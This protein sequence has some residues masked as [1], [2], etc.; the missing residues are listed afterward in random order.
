MSHRFFLL[1]AI[2]VLLFA[3][4]GLAEEHATAPAHES[5]SSAGAHATEHPAIDQRLVPIP[6]SRDTIVTAVWVIV[7]FVALLAILYPTAWKNVLAGLKKREERIRGDI[8]EAEAA[9]AKAEE[10]LRQYNAQLATAEGR[11]R[12]LLAKATADG[13]KLA[14]DI[15]MRAQAE[16]EDAKNRAQRD[17]EAAR[18]QALT[19]IYNHTASLATRIAEKIIG[20]NLNESDQED[21]VR[22]SLDELETIGRN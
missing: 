15:R 1:M 8:A 18:D 11:V 4:L 21:L 12:E 17:I 9:R 20:R 7:I 19:E 22:K 16:A 3:R 14:A 5:I 13:E 10:T 6:P 2:A